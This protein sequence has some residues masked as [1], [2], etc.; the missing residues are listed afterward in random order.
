MA[1][2]T[3]KQD[4]SPADKSSRTN[5]LNDLTA[6]EWL[7]E[8]VSVWTQR[9]LGAGHA[10]AAIER[11]HPAPF[12]YTDV[13]R[14]INMLT[15]A[16]ATVLDPFVGVGSTLKACALTGRNGIGF[17]LYAHF[18]ALTRQRLE[19]E[20]P[21]EALESTAQ[22]I[23]EGDTRILVNKLEDESIDLIVTSPPYWGILNKKPDHKVKSER[24]DSGLS[25]NYG[26]DPRDLAN[27]TDYEGFI[28]E[29]AVSL[30][31]CA[32]ALKHKG[33]MVLV[34]GDFRHKS[35]YYLFHADI[36]RALE[37]RGLTLQAMNV[38]Y[39]RHKR[40]F[41]YGYPYA[42]VPNVHHQNIVVLRKL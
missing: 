3:D 22:T 12:S 42:Y 23:W 16:G 35:R 17:E 9:G 14:I 20:V 34:V 29:L 4:D 5:K 26:D 19:T 31:D 10:D 37:E 27:I 36:A 39:Q 28:E 33:Y 32:R 8:S 15:K 1:K 21:A 11:Q 25:V 7:S 18:A 38:L 13:S 6:K 41:P 30:S 2:S 40:V 24:L